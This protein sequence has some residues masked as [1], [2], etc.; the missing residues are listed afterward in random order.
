MEAAMTKCI[1]CG[2]PLTGGECDN[3]CAQ[4]DIPELNVPIKFWACPYCVGME[5]KWNGNKAWC[6]MCGRSN[7]DSVCQCGEPSCRITINGAFV[8]CCEKCL[9]F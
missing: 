7:D 6:V 9:P 5:V 4:I 3:M 1:K 2:Y 8:G